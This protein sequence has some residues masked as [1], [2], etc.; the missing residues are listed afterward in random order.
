MSC[1][2]SNLIHPLYLQ[3]YDGLCRVD[4]LIL[5]DNLFLNVLLRYF[6]FLINVMYLLI[7]LLFYYLNIFS[8]LSTLFVVYL[9]YEQIPNDFQLLK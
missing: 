5:V 8:V 9:Y 3:R 6:N 1:I 2:L 4:I 7:V